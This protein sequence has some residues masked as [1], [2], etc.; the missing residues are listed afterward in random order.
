MVFIDG[1]NIFH[2]CKDLNFEISYETFVLILKEEKNVVRIFFYSGVKPP[3]ENEKKF[4]KMLKH[5]EIEIIT[6]LLKVRNFQC[7]FCKKRTKIYTEKGID[8]SLSTDLLWYAFQNAYD[9][10]ILV[11]GDADFIPA[12]ERVRLLGKRVEIWTFKHSIGK[13]LKSKV[14]KVNFI[15]DII[16][17]IKK[18]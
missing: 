1:S 8:A 3:K 17:K 4:I 16:E 2:G 12:I 5:L 6:K 14:D 7:K 9:I 18:N 13:E 15:D 10:A 11:S